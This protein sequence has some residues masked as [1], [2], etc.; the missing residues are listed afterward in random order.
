[1]YPL[2]FI[3]LHVLH[4]LFQSQNALSSTLFIDLNVLCESKQ[5]QMN[6]FLK[7]TLWFLCAQ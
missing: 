1:M 6:F 4:I 2:I 7:K 3:L 5:E